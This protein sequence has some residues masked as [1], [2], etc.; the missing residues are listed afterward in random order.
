MSQPPPEKPNAAVALIKLALFTF[1]VPGT[2]TVWAPR[3]FF[4]NAYGAN[5]FENTASLAGGILLLSLGV[6]GYLWC[7]LDFA[8]AG[9]GTPAPIDPPKLLVVRGLYRYARNPMYISVLLVLFG[10]SAL[11]RSWTLCRYAL[12][13]WGGFQLFVLLYEEP[14]LREKFGAS[15]E[16]YCKRVNRWLPRPPRSSAP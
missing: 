14:T 4:R 2:V 5:L 3:Y 12:V 10:E 8:F 15:Y 6:A 7:A 16:D 1:F 11:F 13:V 9:H